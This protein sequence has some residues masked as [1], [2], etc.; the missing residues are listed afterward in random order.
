MGPIV[1]AGYALGVYDLPLFKRCLRNLLIAVVISI[2]TSTIYFLLSPITE[3]Q[4]ELLSRSNPTFYDVLI[5]IFG[6]A[7]GIMALSRKEKSNAIPGVAI[8]TALMPP[9]CAAGFGLANR[10]FLFAGGAFYLFI[11]NCVF[12]SI[13]TFIFVRLLRFEQSQK[14]NLQLRA[15]IS[16]FLSFAAIAIVLPSLYSAWYLQR[17]ATFKYN[18]ENFLKTEIRAKGHLLIHQETDFAI[19]SPHITVTILSD[20]AS[21]N[22]INEIKR[23]SIHYS[24][25]PDQ[26]DIKTSNLNSKIEDQ[27]KSEQSE[28]QKLFS[29]LE[30]RFHVVNNKLKFFDQKLVLEDQILSEIKALYPEVNEVV[31]NFKK[32]D[33]SENYNISVVLFWDKHPP[34]SNVLKINK[35]IQFRLSEEYNCCKHVINPR[36]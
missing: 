7:A 25:S 31:F 27:I 30:Q 14:T 36:P 19:K 3:A 2:T 11:I 5:A 13:S 18:V 4:S 33:N 10:N 16:K 34:K 35:F 24:L 23:R 20:K 22:D 17:K 26:V 21:N 15:K 8:A 12:I 28:S 29:E 6:G 32:T 9:L 1:G